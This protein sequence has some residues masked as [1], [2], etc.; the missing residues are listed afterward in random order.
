MSDVLLTAVTCDYCN[1]TFTT[2]S[3]LH[4]SKFKTPTVSAVMSD[5]GN[6]SHALFK[7]EGVKLHLTHVHFICLLCNHKPQHNSQLDLV[8][9]EWIHHPSIFTIS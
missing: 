7:C 4:L 9:H 3:F 8:I 2:P 1:E 6:S 5:E